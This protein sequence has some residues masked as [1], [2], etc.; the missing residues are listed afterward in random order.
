VE[1]RQKGKG[2]VLL[3]VDTD[4]P[5]TQPKIPEFLEKRGIHA[6]VL[7]GGPQE[8][9]GYETHPGAIYLIDRRGILAGVPGDDYTDNPAKGV[10]ARLPDLL[11]GRPVPGPLL[12]TI[13]KA[14][15]NFGVLW[16]APLEAP[17]EALSIAPPSKGRPAEI[18]VASGSHLVRFSAAGT[19]L[20]DAPLAEGLRFLGGADLDGDGKNE[21]ITSAGNI[22]TLMDAAGEEYW[23]YIAS[24]ESVSVASVLDLDKDGSRE[25]VIQDGPVL[26]ARQ[27]LPGV[28]WK[29]PALAALRSVNL[30]PSGAL[31]VQTRDGI[32]ALGGDG[33]FRGAPLRVQG[34]EILRGRIARDPG[35]YLD[36]FGVDDGAMVDVRHDLDGDGRSDILIS[37]QGVIAVYRQNGSPLLIL[38]ITN[39]WGTPRVAMENLDGRPGDELVLAVPKHGLVAFGCSPSG[40]AQQVQRPARAGDL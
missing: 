36:A 27:A 38:A 4:D 14:P 22:V 18:G 40:K 6:K 37:N 5:S 12:W 7:L 10:E 33:T 34:N 39:N 24:G 2:F 9:R 25:I 26:V 31:L 8:P 30:D 35:G 17:A 16:K 15:R 21:W 20:G 11:A 23:T 32:Q 19:L 3:A 28:L 29:T 1:E 13:E